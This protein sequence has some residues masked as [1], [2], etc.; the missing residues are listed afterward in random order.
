VEEG[1]LTQ[2]FLLQ[3]EKRALRRPFLL[4]ES[5]RTP[6]FRVRNPVRRRASS[7]R[8]MSSSSVRV[9]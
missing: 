5:E 1:R 8:G 6:A 7:A 9:K 2:A 4:V 3:D